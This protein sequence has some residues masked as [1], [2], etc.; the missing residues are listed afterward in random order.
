MAFCPIYNTDIFAF[1]AK[2]LVE[3]CAL[4]FGDRPSPLAA[5]AVERLPACALPFAC[6]LLPPSQPTLALATAQSCAQPPPVSYEPQVSQP[7]TARANW[8]T[9]WR[10]Q[11]ILNFV[12]FSSYQL[13]SCSVISRNT[14]YYYLVSDFL[15]DFGLRPEGDWEEGSF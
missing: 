13:N 7:K 3:D 12:F 10:K 4:L 2:L 5:V 11:I 8:Q 6:A 14:V 1:S 9:C 15:C